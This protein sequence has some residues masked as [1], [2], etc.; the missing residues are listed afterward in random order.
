MATGHDTPPGLDMLI[1][2]FH[3]VEGLVADVV[4][5][6]TLD[7]LSWR[8]DADANPIGWLVWHLTRVQDDHLADILG[9]PQVW[10]A[11]GWE[12]R[13]ALAY[14]DDAI[15]YGQSP[16]EVGAFRLSDPVVLTAY[17]AAVSRRTTGALST[18]EP[19]VLDRVVDAS[20]DPPVTAAVRLV[21]VLNDVTQHIGQAAYV[22]GLV[23][24]RRIQGTQP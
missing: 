8:P 23:E 22:R 5:G 2:G 18:L 6:L 3:R 9:E 10:H 4:E 11:D 16:K 15:G 13:F 21:S 1:D 17:H 12:G 20:Y 14:P 7:E 24:R 19:A